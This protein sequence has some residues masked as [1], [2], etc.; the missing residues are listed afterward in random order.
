MTEKENKKTPVVFAGIKFFDVI[1]ENLRACD[2]CAMVG[3]Y[4][5]WVL[6]LLKLSYKVKPFGYKKRI[7][8]IITRLENCTTSLSQIRHAKSNGNMGWESLLDKTVKKIRECE[9]ELYEEARDLLLKSAAEDVDS[10]NWDQ[11][12]R[13]MT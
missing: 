1:I 8:E 5:R 4:D 12:Q 3:D 10:I 2:N 9:M 11:W 13:G 7:D 6:A